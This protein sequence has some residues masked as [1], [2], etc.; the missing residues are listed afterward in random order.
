MCVFPAQSTID[1]KKWH[2]RFSQRRKSNC[3][4]QS[5]NP[6][7]MNL[8]SGKFSMV[9]NEVVQTYIDSTLVDHTEKLQE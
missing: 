1:K 9:I 2:E 7:K 3:H 4:G 5:E 6:T 8:I